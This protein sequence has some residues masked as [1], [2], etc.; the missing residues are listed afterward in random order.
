MAIVALVE[1]F[2]RS[3]CPNVQVSAIRETTRLFFFLPRAELKDKKCKDLAVAINYA[4]VY[5]HYDVVHTLLCHNC[6]RGPSTSPKCNWKQLGLRHLNDSLVTNCD[7]MKNLSTID[8][9]YNTLQSVAEEL[10]QLDNLN[11]LLLCNNSLQELPVDLPWVTQTLRTLHLSQNSLSTLPK[12]FADSKI[13]ELYLDK[14]SFHSIPQCVLQLTCLKNLNIKDNPAI[15]EI[16]DELGK[17]RR[18]CTFKFDVAK[19]R[20]QS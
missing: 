3:R 18:L 10:F 5:H 4:E 13:I 19:V 11:T 6:L 15:T 8:L 14:N 16:P 9:R 7:F 20:M 17:L 1:H 12:C 2:S